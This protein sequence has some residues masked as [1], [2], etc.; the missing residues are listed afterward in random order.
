MFEQKT[1]QE[2]LDYIKSDRDE[3]RFVARVF[4]VN[5]LGTYYSF[6][7]TLSEKADITVR[8][9]DERFCKGSDTVPD[10]KALI[11]VLD[12]NKDKDILVPHLAEYLRIGEATEKN[13]ACLYS[14][15]NRHVQF[16]FF[17]DSTFFIVAIGNPLVDRYVMQSCNSSSPTIRQR[18]INTSGDANIVKIV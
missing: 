7:K 11:T 1:L 13:S 17:Y 3:N 14:I 8:L 9:S 15:L 4:F 2:V 12:E 16:Q 10:L 6:I 18:R 5:N